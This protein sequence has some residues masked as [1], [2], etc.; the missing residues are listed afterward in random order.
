MWKFVDQ[1]LFY[2]FSSQSQ[3]FLFPFVCL[4]FCSSV[5]HFSIRL[6]HI[7]Y[8]N[9]SLSNS[10][11]LLLHLFLSP[12]S[13][14]SVFLL[15]SLSIPCVGRSLRSLSASPHEAINQIPWQPQNSMSYHYVVTTK[16][17]M[18][19]G[20]ERVALS[21]AEQERRELMGRRN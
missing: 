14:L 12:F 18:L 5:T 17:Q 4:M 1:L 16:S 9:L 3:F 13:S 21:L 2:Q 6:F 15:L 19:G 20:R 7:L 11:H 10:L 8:L